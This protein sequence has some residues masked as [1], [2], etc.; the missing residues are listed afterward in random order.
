MGYRLPLPEH[1][2]TP[3]SLK[4]FISEKLIF[5]LYWVVI[6][7]TK[8][9]EMN[10]NKKRIADIELICSI[11]SSNNIKSLEQ[12]ITVYISEL[13]SDLSGNPEIGY[14][15]CELSFCSTL[16]EIDRNIDLGEMLVISETKTNYKQLIEWC[17]DEAL[18]DE[19]LDN[20]KEIDSIEPKGED[21]EDAIIVSW[22]WEK[23][24]GYC[25][26]FTGL[27]RGTYKETEH[28]LITGN[29]ECTFRGNMSVLLTK[30]EV[31]DLSDEEILEAC[32]KELDKESWKWNYFRN[33]PT[34]SKIISEL[35][36][37]ILE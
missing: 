2:T 7:K 9:K 25:R 27:R 14:S 22:N 10:L 28:D 5:P 29:E 24:I 36:S 33:N 37:K 32:E 26:N 21:I 1:P 35:G 13:H 34:Q 6:P 30:E 18:T 4:N 12:P 19:L 16:E 11:R 15:N 20:R 23:Y 31:K 8:T 3:K 17:L